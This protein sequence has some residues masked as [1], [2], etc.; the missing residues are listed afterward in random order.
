MRNRPRYVFI[1]S[2]VR[3]GSTFVAEAV[4]YSAEQAD[5]QLFD[6]TKEPF[7][8]VDD[9]HGAADI[10]ARLS[11]LR[12]DCSA[13]EFVT[14]CKWLVP[15]LAR[16]WQLSEVS[17]SLAHVLF[18]PDTAWLVVSRQN[19]VGQ[20]MS[21]AAARSTGLWHE[22]GE[23][24]V[25]KRPGLAQAGDEAFVASTVDLVE[26]LA[27][28]R[29]FLEVF[30]DHVRDTA[31]SVHEITYEAFLEDPSAQLTEIQRG[32]GLAI[33]DYA[34]VKIRRSP[35]SRYPPGASADVRRRF[36][37]RAVAPAA[38]DQ[39]LVTEWE[40][41]IQRAT[42]LLSQSVLLG[43][44]DS[45]ATV[46]VA[47][48]SAGAVSSS[49]AER[50]VGDVL[51]L[52]THDVVKD[53]RRSRFRRRMLRRTPTL[54][55]LVGE[56]GRLPLAPDS[57]DVLLLV[58]LLA[59]RVDID[60]VLREATRVLRHD[61]KLIVSVA[62]FFDT[63]RG[64]QIFEAAEDLSWLHVE[65][66]AAFRTAVRERHGQHRLDDY[67]S[68]AKLSYPALV[69]QLE[70]YGFRTTAAFTRSTKVPLHIQSL[71]AGEV[72]TVDMSIVVAG[73]GNS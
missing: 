47:E 10:L 37:A 62:P 28:S 18:G 1:A 30:A 65:D 20:A 43:Q 59:Q 70:C 50:A 25:E 9:S 48:R 31:A 66:E 3:S 11:R 38:G 27:S 41:D 21:L 69:E 22:Y 13:D 60:S 56:L 33:V 32:L 58:D 49:L 15:A 40:E 4:A 29:V 5:V 44:F 72:S 53:F 8:D 45:V 26:T 34:G 12:D 24:E 68:L 14:S 67:D 17:E 64:H 36:I 42:W 7:N 54:R 71:L 23:P 73:M 19:V 2:E 63:E 55:P 57:A 35:A 51:A 52:T 16:A 6:L 61:G 39:D 46:V